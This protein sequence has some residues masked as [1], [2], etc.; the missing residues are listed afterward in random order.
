MHFIAQSWHLFS[1]GDVISRMRTA[2]QSEV[3]GVLLLLERIYHLEM[4]D[5]LDTEKAPDSA[6][7]DSPQST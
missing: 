7:F 6:G 1:S 2:I 5:M 4:E 3:E